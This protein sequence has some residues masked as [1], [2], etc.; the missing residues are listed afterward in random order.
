MFPVYSHARAP[1]E[2][3]IDPRTRHLFRDGANDVALSSDYRYA[4][5]TT[6]FRFGAQL[7]VIP[8]P[9]RLRTQDDRSRMRVLDRWMR[10]INSP[11]K[12]PKLIAL[13]DRIVQEKAPNGNSYERARVLEMHFA[14]ERSY[15]Y[16]L[17]LDQVRSKREQG[18]DPIEVVRRSGQ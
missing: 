2:L 3:R 8:H 11:E 14:A 7:Q 4:I 6:A 9:N 16:T 15:N 5:V 10:N 12:L 17:D 13:A 1:E 18:V